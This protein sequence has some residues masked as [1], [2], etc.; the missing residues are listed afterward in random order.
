MLF[1]SVDEIIKSGYFH[2][3]SKESLTDKQLNKN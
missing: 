1:S 2:H 3:L